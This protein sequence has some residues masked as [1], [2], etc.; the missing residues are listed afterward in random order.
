[1]EGQHPDV[2]LLAR[3]VSRFVQTRPTMHD[4]ARRHVA[5]RG[6]TLVDDPA[7]AELTFGVETGTYA[8][9][10]PAKILSDLI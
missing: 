5:A 2:A 4:L 3:E 1:M 6:T 8:A 10:D 9:G 7:E